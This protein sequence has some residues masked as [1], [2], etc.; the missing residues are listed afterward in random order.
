MENRL[1]LGEKEGENLQSER[2][3]RAGNS[4]VGAA[5]KPTAGKIPLTETYS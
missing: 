4:E 2:R 3:G 5:E 1:G